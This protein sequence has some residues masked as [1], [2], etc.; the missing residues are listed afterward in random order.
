MSEIRIVNLMPHTATLR[1]A[2]GF[3]HVIAP[4]GTIA[5]VSTTPGALREVE[6]LP[7]PVA[8]A[9]VYGEIEGLPEPQDGTI[10]VVSALVLGRAVGRT[11]V[12]AP[13][14]GPQDGAIRDDA[15][16]IVAVTRLV[17]APLS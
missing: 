16:R 17:G 6:G 8:S 7:V 12:F 4:S 1:D 14:T 11:D 10:Y 2:Y 15:G 13:G 5:R 9:T 3:D